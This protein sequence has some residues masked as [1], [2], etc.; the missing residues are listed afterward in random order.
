MSFKSTKQ[1]V[2]FLFETSKTNKSS[3]DEWD[4]YDDDW[5]PE[6]PTEEER[7]AAREEERRKKQR[8]IEFAKNNPERFLGGGVDPYL[9]YEG[10]RDHAGENSEMVLLGLDPYRKPVREFKSV[11]SFVNYLFEQAESEEKSKS[12]EDMSPKEMVAA[13]IDNTPSEYMERSLAQRSPGPDAAGSTF[14]EK[15]T[16][17]SLKQA[18]WK[19][20]THNPEAITSPAI[21][22]EANIPGKLG[23]AD[24]NDYPDDMEAVIQPSHGGKGIHRASGKLMAEIAAVMPDGMPIVDFTTIILG[25][26]KSGQQVVYTF[27][28]G[29]P[30]AQGTPV[31]MEDMKKEFGTEDDKILTTVGKAKELGFVTLKHIDVLPAKKEAETLQE[32]FLFRKNRRHRE[33]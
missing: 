21:A 19:P 3:I 11:N 16:P 29:A 2:N 22:F 24:I 12:E 9:R 7:E 8:E 26:D 15:Q 33:F 27:H 13:A 25:P 17:E 14:I 31:F 5:R 6:P 18:D 4:Q 23:A 32:G 20:L 30:A 10:K 1:F 28:P